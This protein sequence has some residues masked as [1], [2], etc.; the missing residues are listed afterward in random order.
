MWLNKPPGSDHSTPPHQD[1]IAFCLQPPSGIQLFLAI[2]PIDVEN[3]CL[4][5]LPGSH[6]GGLRPHA[7]SGVRG[8]SLGIVGYTEAEAEAEVAV[9]L[10]PGDIVGHHPNIVHRAMANRSTTR[11]RAAF[12][13]TFEGQSARI[14]E[15][16]MAEAERWAA[17][18]LREGR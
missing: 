5:Y 2:D 1:N 10:C 6:V 12:A 8:F 16:A 4:R 14:D 15:Q 13:M 11:S 3:G 18:G 7:Y 9:E 17:L